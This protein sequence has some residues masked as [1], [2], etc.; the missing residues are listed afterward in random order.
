M[1]LFAKLKHE[2]LLV[3]PP[4]IFFF[5]AF[6]LLATTQ[7]LI[8][9]EY[10]FSLTGLSVAVIGALIVGKVVLIVDSLPFMNQFPDKPLLYNIAW[11][12]SIY[13]LSTFV[14]R[15]IEHVIPLLREYG[16][17]MEANR[18][19]LAKV[20]WPHFWIIQMWLAVLFFLYCS[21][22]ELVRVIGREKVVRIFLVG[23][24]P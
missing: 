20:V 6:L 1:K 7:R 22:R 12:S 16:E 23:K 4:T 8:Q 5:F 18:Q 15:Y 13:F 14:V 24:V 21:L 9:R 17:F 2:F 3:L 11:K 19:L 10:G